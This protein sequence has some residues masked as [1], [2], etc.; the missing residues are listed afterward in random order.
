MKTNLKPPFLKSSILLSVG[1]AASSLPLFGTNVQAQDG[2]SSEPMVT[3]L[4]S[5]DM[6]EAD[7]LANQGFI[8]AQEVEGGTEFSFVSAFQRLPIEG[9]VETSDMPV[10]FRA[11]NTLVFS[12]ASLDDAR[13]QLFTGNPIYYNTLLGRAADTEVTDDERMTVN[14]NL[15]CSDQTGENTDEQPITEERSQPNPNLDLSNLPDG[16]YRVVS[17]D[18]PMR[19]VSDEELLEAGGALFLFQKV[20]DR[21]TGIYGFID[22]EGGSCITG[23]LSDNRVM[24]DAYAY[25]D[26]IRSGV[27]LTL[28]DDFEDGFYLDSVLDL[29]SFSRINAGTRLPVTDCPL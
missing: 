25:S 6:G 28:G 15:D 9:T 3:C 1:L 13:S 18:F 22:H 29:S 11:T 12:G 14:E 16:N 26:A 8:T 23:T 5:A 19:V 7:P 17:A 2:L 4:Y 27:F 10:G 24:G 20:G 21:I